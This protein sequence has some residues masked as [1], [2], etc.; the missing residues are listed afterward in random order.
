QWVETRPSGGVFPISLT[1]NHRILYVLN[2][3]AAAGGTD[4]IAGFSVSN[5]GHLTAIASGLAL[6]SPNVGPAQIGFDTDGDLLLVTEKSTN[7]L[8]VFSVDANGVASGPTVLPSA[9]QTPFGFAFGK[10]SQ[11]FVSEAFGGAAN[12]SAVSSYRVTAGG[13]LQT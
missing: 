2:N 5:E 6:S 10:R 11:V 13:S 3:G 1:V 12:A 7:N 8:D 4:N 9:G